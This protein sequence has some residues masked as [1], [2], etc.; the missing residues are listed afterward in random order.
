MPATLEEVLAQSD[1]V[2]MHA[3]AHAGSA[4]HAQGEAFPPDE[5]RPPCSSTPA[6]ARRCDEAA[7]IKALQEGWIA[8][9]GLDVLEVEPPGHNNPLLKMDN[10]TLSAHTSP[11]PPRVSTRRASGASAR[12]WRWC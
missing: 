2:S 6:A 10:V 4:R 12:I 5:E 9:A 7:L 11:R 3:P 8:H 1:F